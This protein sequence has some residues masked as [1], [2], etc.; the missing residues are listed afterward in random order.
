MNIYNKLFRDKIP[1]II[2]LTR[3]SRYSCNEEEYT[4]MLN[5]KLQE[6]LDVYKVAGAADQF[7]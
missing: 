4:K 7:A 5:L 3:K 2:E 1:Q 6:E